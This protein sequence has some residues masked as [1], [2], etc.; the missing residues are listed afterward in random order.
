MRT[1]QPDN[2]T[3]MEN[4][5]P[6]INLERSPERLHSPFGHIDKFAISSK[7]IPAKH[8][9]QDNLR[10]SN[11]YVTAKCHREI[12]FLSCTPYSHNLRIRPLHPHKSPR[13]LQTPLTIEEWTKVYEYAHRGSLNVAIQKKRVQGR[14]QGVQDP[15]TAQQIFI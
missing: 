15:L 11:L 13:D 8:T 4:P 6:Q 7:L 14:H 3:L 2:S 1:C 12:L 9:G 5:S 10:P